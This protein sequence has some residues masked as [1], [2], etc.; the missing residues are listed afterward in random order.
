[1]NDHVILSTN[2]LN[3]LLEKYV[4][5]SFTISRDAFYFWHNYLNNRCFSASTKTSA[6]S[7]LVRQDIKANLNTSSVSII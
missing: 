4:Y 7:D 6:N 3:I 5:Q 1:M 2:L